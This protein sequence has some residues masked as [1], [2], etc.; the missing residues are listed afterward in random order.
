SAIVKASEEE[1]LSLNSNGDMDAAVQ[2]LWHGRLKCFSVTCGEAGAVLYT[3]AGKFF[4]AGFKVDAVDTTGAGDA[5]VASFLSGLLHG[6]E[7]QKL[8]NTACA[9]GALAASKKGA[10]ESLPTKVELAEFLAKAA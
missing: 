10:M 6:T 8:L 3:P 7:P 4:C 9:A 5:Y 2:A 1:L